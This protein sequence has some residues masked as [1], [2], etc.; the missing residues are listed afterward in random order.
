MMRLIWSVPAIVL[1]STQQ[2][3]SD[4]LNEGW[5]KAKGRYLQI[6]QRDV[7]GFWHR[8]NHSAGQ[9]SI[10]N[11]LPRERLKF[12][13]CFTI[14]QMLRFSCSAAKRVFMSRVAL[15]SKRDTI[16]CTFIGL[17][18]ETSCSDQWS[19]NWL[20]IKSC[21]RPLTSLAGIYGIAMLA[22]FLLL[23]LAFCFLAYASWNSKR[24]HIF[25]KCS[26]LKARQACLQ[27]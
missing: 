9:G 19:R 22:F 18:S 27:N 1:N 20:H 8:L 16:L 11:L 4:K 13:A 15:R 23:I 7:Q 17:F 12:M 5:R 6:C 10:F 21:P 25:W 24:L 3:D 2:W 14:S 26:I